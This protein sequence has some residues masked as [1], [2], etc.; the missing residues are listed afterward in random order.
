MGTSLG[1]NEKDKNGVL[2]EDTFT[3]EMEYYVNN[4]CNRGVHWK[5]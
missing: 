1:S 3:I 4:A 2:S 5:M